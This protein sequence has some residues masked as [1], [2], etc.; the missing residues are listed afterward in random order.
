MKYFTSSLL[1]LFTLTIGC[2]EDT[3]KKLNEPNLNGEG[4]EIDDI[5]I[6]ESEPQLNFLY[7]ISS[8]DGYE[9]SDQD[10]QEFLRLHKNRDNNISNSPLALT[11][12]FKHTASSRAK[13]K[14][15]SS[16]IFSPQGPARNKVVDVTSLNRK[17]GI[18]AV[19]ANKNR[20]AP[21]KN[22][23][24]FN[25]RYFRTTDLTYRIM[26]EGDALNGHGVKGFMSHVE[27]TIESGE[28]VDIYFKHVPFRSENKEFIQIR[29]HIENL[30]LANLKKTPNVAISEK[31]I[32]VQ[33]KGPYYGLQRHV[34]LIQ[35]KPKKPLK[36]PS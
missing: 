23:F 3:D 32:K 15:L 16:V 34:T 20:E 27:S 24:E 9:M 26:K 13:T 25:G 4:N 21:N 36:K 22:N 6:S 1:L 7:V 17:N 33:E 30:F 11:N 31:I 12:Y 14:Q 35:L 18:L 8:N 10:H 5:G 19:S 2:K 29:D 28:A